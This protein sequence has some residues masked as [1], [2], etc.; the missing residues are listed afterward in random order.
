MSAER[1]WARHYMDV[2]EARAG[3]PRMP[4]WLRVAAVAYSRHEN[5]GHARFKRGEIALILASVNAQTGEIRPHPWVGRDINLAVEYGWLAP[6]SYWGCLI[7]PAHNVRKGDMFAPAK[8]CPIHIKRRQR[9]SA[10]SSITE[11]FSTPKPAIT[12]AFSKR[13]H[14]SVRTSERAPLSLIC[15]PQPTTTEG[16]LSA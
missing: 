10:K 5:N 12:E 15:S 6:E 2:W 13:T 16:D 9:E 1:P 8:P 14:H 7:V 11:D 3:D 4:Y